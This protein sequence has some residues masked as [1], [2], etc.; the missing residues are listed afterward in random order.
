[1]NTTKKTNNKTIRLT[2]ENAHMYLGSEVMF[3]TYN[4]DT[5]RWNHVVCRV[6]RISKNSIGVE[7]PALNNNVEFVSQSIYVLLD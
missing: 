1:M 5:L 7:C 3:R 6:L 4:K 2:A